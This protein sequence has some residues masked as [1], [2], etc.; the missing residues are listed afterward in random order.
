M[1]KILKLLLVGSLFG[2]FTLNN[3]F[4]EDKQDFSGQTVS[5]GVASEYEED[6]W[7]S[8]ADLAEEEEGIKIKLVLFSDYVQPN[9]SLSDGSIDLNA[10]QHVEFLNDW[11]QANE[12]DLVS[13]GYTYVAPLKVYSEKIDALDQLKEGDKIAIPNDA[14]NAGRALLA[15]EQ[16]GVIEVDDEAGVLAE[17]SDITKNEL[18]LKFEE[19]DAAQLVPS[20]PDVAAA[21][22]NNNFANDAELEEDLVIFND[23]EDIEKLPDSYKNIIASR[24]EESENPLFL[25]IV[26]LYQSEETVKKLEEVSK[27]SD[28]PAW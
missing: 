16:A 13:I 21:V 18:N 14:T 5:V 24:K 7:Q 25:K 20:L 27:G 9:I 28:Q 8:V 1:K 22:I 19:L 12:G 3:V 26:E 23:A 17:V 2:S 15:L 10:F 11:N 4:A 6:V